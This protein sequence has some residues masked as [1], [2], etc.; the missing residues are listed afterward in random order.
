MS[1]PSSK[2][3]VA[4]V[5]AL[6]IPLLTC[7][8]EPEV[9]P[10]EYETLI[11]SNLVGSGSHFEMRGERYIACSLHQTEGEVPES[12]ISLD[13]DEPVTIT[14]RVKRGHDTQVLRYRCAPLDEIP[15]LVFN[16]D[17]KTEV[18]DPVFVYNDEGPARGVI[19][20]R[21]S[22]NRCTVRMD[23]PFAAR[24][25]SGSPILN[26][27]TGTVI[28]VLLDADDPDAATVIGFEL[29]KLD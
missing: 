18:G 28:G 20:R 8:A 6:L 3:I 12:M 11:G 19:E 14:G 22:K 23:Q 1:R 2:A 26:A 25:A 29:L 13:I 16:P 17:L 24:G 5:C 21:R 9:S 15:A 4:A 7:N 10:P 27:R